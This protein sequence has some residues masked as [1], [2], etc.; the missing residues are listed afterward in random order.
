MKTKPE[1]NRESA[2]AKLGEILA[3]LARV[4]PG[5]Y[6]G[7]ARRI[8]ETNGS[9]STLPV[10]RRKLATVGSGRP[11]V[12]SFE[13]LEALDQ[14]LVRERGTGLR[15]IFRSPGILEMA[16]AKGKV[17]FLIGAKEWEGRTMVSLW[18]LR[19]IEQVLGGVYR[20]QKAVEIDIRDV[21]LRGGATPQVSSQ[22]QGQD[23]V[24]LEQLIDHVDS[25]S[26]VSL[27]SPRACHASEVLLGRMFCLPAFQ[28]KPATALQSPFSFLWSYSPDMHPFQSSFS[29]TPQQIYQVGWTV[30]PLDWQTWGLRTVRRDAQNLP[31]PEI[32]QVRGKGRRWTT[33]GLIAAQRQPSGQV[34]IVL[35][36]L[37]GPE[38]LACAKILNSV[39]TALKPPQVGRRAPVFWAV[40]ESDVEV[41]EK[42]GEQGKS[43]GDGRRLLDQRIVFEQ[44]WSPPAPADQ[45]ERRGS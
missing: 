29:L 6:K 21:P 42:S 45:I 8:A 12:F 22:G 11:A 20:S 26:L 3:E 15:A 36:G 16:A 9:G 30:D 43:E 18:D 24:P 4:Q 7:L 27:G 39:S 35:A 19:S 23:L 34:W 32:R 28:S 38:T 33:Y 44:F 2:L 31:C 25:P 41:P 5:G 14:F 17:V 13:E 1:P 37:S 40:I 10:D